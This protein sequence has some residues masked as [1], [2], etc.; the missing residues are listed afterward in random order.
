MAT[1]EQFYIRGILKNA[2]GTAL[3]SATVKA[4]RLQSA[5]VAASLI[6]S[7]QYTTDEFSA[8][9]DANGV[10]E[11]LVTHALAATCPLTYRVDLPD[12]RYFL[13]HFLPGEG[14]YM[15]VGTLLC[16]QTPGSPLQTINITDLVQKNMSRGLNA[17]RPVASAATVKLT[18][19]A[20]GA[21]HVTTVRMNGV[22]VTAGNTTGVSFGGTKIVDFPEGRINVLASRL[23]EEI[24]FGLTNA[25]N[26]TPITGAMG[27]DI[28]LGSTVAGDGTLTGT[29]VDLIP[30][31][32]ID[33]ISG[34][35]GLAHLAAGFA[36]NGTSS[37][38]DAYINVLIDD[39][40]VANGASDVLEVSGV[41]EITWV[42]MGD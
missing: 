2:A 35:S 42:Y 15:D 26:A 22:L 3:A 29:D 41:W 1:D 33:P 27:G 17:V 21:L 40:D 19:Q 28:A 31:T 39:A 6:D 38:L 20:F 36:Y 4:K 8:T 24:A 11:I 23:V 10:F 7:S 30:S 9:T 25:G 16:E 13:L 34:G 5:A 37:P 32:S 12:K 18:D 14:G